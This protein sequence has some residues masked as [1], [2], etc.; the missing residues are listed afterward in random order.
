MGQIFD[1]FKPKGILNFRS[2]INSPTEGVMSIEGKTREFT[3]SLTRNNE[4]LMRYNENDEYVVIN[5]V[6]IPLKCDSWSNWPLEFFL[7]DKHYTHKFKKF[8]LLKY[9]M[10]N[11]ILCEGDEIA[12]IIYRIDSQ[13]LFFNLGGRLKMELDDRVSFLE[14]LFYCIAWWWTG[15]YTDNTSA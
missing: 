6:Q 2:T 8:L 4:L 5:G 9:S 15:Y 14:P 3:F 7:N 11:S 13:L 10:Q 12:N 1:I